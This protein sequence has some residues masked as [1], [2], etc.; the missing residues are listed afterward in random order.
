MTVSI[1]FLILTIA[2]LA[3]FI[4]SDLYSAH[5][6]ENKNTGTTLNMQNIFFLKKI[7]LFVSILSLLALLV[8][9]S[10]KR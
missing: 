7:F 10:L 2:L 1:F 9:A 8:S 6:L 5:L 3:L 4:L